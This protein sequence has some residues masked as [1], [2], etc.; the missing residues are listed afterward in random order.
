MRQRW[1]DVVFI[2]WETDPDAARAALPAGFGLDQ[3]AGRTYVGLVALQIDVLLGHHPV[4][5]VGSFPELNVRLYSVDPTGR[6]GIAFCSMDAGRLLPAVAGRAG[7][8]LPYT[9]ADATVSR[10]GQAVAY[11]VERR[12]PGGRHPGCRF[13]VRVGG[14]IARPSPLETFLTARWAL[15]WSA[16]GRPWWCA[17]DHPPWALHTAELESIDDDL[18]Q[19]AGLP[20]PAGP[21]SVLWS[22]GTRAAIGRPRSA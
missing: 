9:W 16:A 20:T 14:R 8:R 17:V 11:R 15:H 7:Y 21:V 18:V 2:H 13:S 22:P 5:Y 4:P 6:R 1:R 19:A 3:H 12:W 10:Q